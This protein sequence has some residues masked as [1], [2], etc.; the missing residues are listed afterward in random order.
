MFFKGVR[1]T[2]EANH[3]WAYIQKNIVLLDDKNGP[4]DTTKMPTGLPTYEDLTKPLGQSYKEQLESQV[5]S[6]QDLLI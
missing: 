2:P 4:I 5:G 6:I 3:I 1:L